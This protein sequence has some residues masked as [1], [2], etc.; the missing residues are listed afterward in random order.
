MKPLK[1]VTWNIHKGIGGAD[2]RYDFGR[3]LGVLDRL[4]P[5]LICLQE[6]AVDLP[7]A[8]HHDQ[9]KLLA[10]YFPTLHPFF[11]QTVH[12]KKGGYGNLILS[13][14]PFLE[15]HRISL[16][17]KNRK[18]RGAILAKVDTPGRPLTLVNWHLGLGAGE[19]LWQVQH[20]LRHD[21]WRAAADESAVI[22]GDF[23][24]WRNLLGPNLLEPAGLRQASAPPARFRSFPAALPTLSLDKVF[25]TPDITPHKIHVVKGAWVRP[26]SDH[27]PVEAQ[28]SLG[29]PLA[30]A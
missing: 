4:A 2:R 1:L 29:A 14:F 25:H 15:K 20:L 6:V 18:V 12:W 23:N 22:A 30:S 21:L 17:Y 10:D 5:D 26:A 11:Q 8:R 19:R 9:P 13:R 16:Q 24:D 28:L 3:I 27:L 7:S